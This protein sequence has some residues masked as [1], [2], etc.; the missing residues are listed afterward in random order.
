M[1]TSVSIHSTPCLLVGDLG[2]NKGDAMFVLGDELLAGLH[3]RRP[4]DKVLYVIAQS[5]VRYGCKDNSRDR[6]NRAADP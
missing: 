5:V 4:M 2:V 1:H 3:C 6:G